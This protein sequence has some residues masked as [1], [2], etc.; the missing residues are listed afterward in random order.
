M[1]LTILMASV[2]AYMIFKGIDFATI[3]SNNHASPNGA[4]PFLLPASGSP[5]A[6]EAVRPVASTRIE[7]W[8]GLQTKDGGKEINMQKLVPRLVHGRNKTPAARS[9]Q[10][11]ATK[12]TSP[13]STP[14]SVMPTC[15]PPLFLVEPCNNVHTL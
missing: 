11:C 4:L 2:Q 13:S 3:S 7:R 6:T 5:N 14:A 1:S 15:V 10:I 8:V 12:L 9:L